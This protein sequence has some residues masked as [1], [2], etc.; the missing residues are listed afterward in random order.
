MLEKFD[1]FVN[2]CFLHGGTLRNHK[3]FG[4][5]AKEL[6][7]MIVTAQQERGVDWGKPGSEITT[8]AEFEDD[9][10]VRLVTERDK[11]ANK[12]THVTFLG[13]PIEYAPCPICG[14]HYWCLHR[15]NLAGG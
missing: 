15:E 3:A 1:S 12:Y 5:M 11:A 8:T 9:E 2:F 7:A 4:E 6:R 13:D 14:T 10:L